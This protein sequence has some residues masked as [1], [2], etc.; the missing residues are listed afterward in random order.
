MLNALLKLLY[1]GIVLGFGMVVGI[2][3]AIHLLTEGTFSWEG[4]VQGVL[5]LMILG[6][7]LFGR[8]VYQEYSAVVKSKGRHG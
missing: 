3:L 8:L 7:I 6:A 5:L 2:K 1:K 4:M